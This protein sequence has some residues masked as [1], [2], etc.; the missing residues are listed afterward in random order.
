M[1]FRTIPLLLLCLAACTQAPIR[2]PDTSFEEE[3]LA[4]F[5]GIGVATL[6]VA[7]AAEKESGTRVEAFTARDAELRDTL[8]TLFKDSD[9]NVLVDENVGGRASFDIK[10]A[11]LEESFEALLESYDLAYRWDGNFLRVESSASRVFDV[12]YPGEAASSS[13]VLGSSDGGGGGTEA[14][15]SSG[16]DEFWDR[17]ETDLALVAAGSERIVINR[18]LGTVGVEAKPKTLR[19]VDE[20]LRQARRRATRQVSIE[21]RIVE[22]SLRKEFKA[23]V[24]W[25][26][27]PGF[28]N[29]SKTGSLPGGAIFQQSASSGA[30]AFR[31][32]LVNAGN[33]A[34]FL[35]ALELQGQVRVLSS[36]RVATLHNVPAQI[37]VVEQ[38]PVIE[39]EIIDTDSASR[40]QFS[41]RFED[42]GV[43]VSVT[44]QI[45]EDGVITAHIRPSIVEV[46]GYITT[47]DKLVT[48]P[49]LNTRSVTTI[50]RVQD[51]QPIVLGG[52]RSERKTET[53]NKVPLLGDIPVVGNLF[54]TTTQE[55]VDTELVILL[56]PRILT[57]AWEREDLHRSLDRIR[58]IHVPFRPSTIP[59]QQERID[60]GTFALEG[61][62]PAD[63]D[64]ETKRGVAAKADSPTPSQPRLTRKGLARLAFRHALRAIE[65]GEV[66]PALRAL[67]E[68]SQLDESL[69]DAWLVRGTLEFGRGRVERA[70]EAFR[71]VLSTRPDDP[72]ASNSLGLIALRRGDALR[73]EALFRQ[74]LARGSSEEA[75]NNLGVALLAQGRIAEARAQFAQV[76]RDAPTMVEAS[77]NAAVCHDRS[78]EPR[79][80]ADAYRTFVRSGGRLDDPRV[81]AL[82]SRIDAILAQPVATSSRTRAADVPAATELDR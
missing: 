25:S 31:F 27:L 67:D 77:L 28:L 24:D 50:L 4:T 3:A 9:V 10:S 45:G 66:T 53:L 17:L 2:Q 60:I 34:V 68:A 73:A 12:D 33:F 23:G 59:M 7:F 30:E 54:R 51:G 47:P 22:V 18:R 16:Q 32:G 39:R 5:P 69:A 52:L 61:T 46:S 26:I 62:T 15:S 42:A 76:M 19:R 63:E 64:A 56:T 70:R 58:R 37:R 21:A 29:T 81:G 80:A 35:D 8:M 49:I 40:T 36:P 74:I 41:V 14:G 38:V 6:P 75:R 44:P 78:G 71:K 57:S 72:H 55:R 43:T 79:L 20:Y 48:E 13:G 65:R 1:I 82:R 11:S